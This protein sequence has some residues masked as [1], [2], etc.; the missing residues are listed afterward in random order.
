M[1]YKFPKTVVIWLCLGSSTTALAQT[2]ADTSPPSDSG[3][4]EEIVVT[5]QKRQ[6]SLNDVGLT[7]TAAT[8]DTL[9]KRGVTEVGDL[10]KIVPG[11]TTTSTQYS[12]PVYQLRG[13]GLYDY[14]FGSLPP[15]AVYIDEISRPFPLTQI[16]V[17]LDIERVEVLKGPQGTLYGQSSTGGA[18]N[19]ITAKPT[20]I[21]SAG[22]DASYERFGKMSLSGFVSGPLTDTLKARIALKGVNGGAWQYSVARPDDKNGETDQLMGRLIVDFEPTDTL[23]F[24]LNVNGIRDSSDTVQPQFQYNSINLTP[25]AGSSNPFAQVDPAAY[26]GLTSPSSPNFD[27]SFFHRQEVVLARRAG[28]PW[29]AGALLVPNDPANATAYLAGPN[30]DG[31]ALCDSN[32]D[33]CIRQA[34]WTPGWTHSKVSLYQVAFRADYDLSDNVTITSLTS[35]LKNK[36][37]R[38]TDEDATTAAGYQVNIF[39]DIKTFS[40]ELRLSGKSAGL[41]WVIGGNFDTSKVEQHAAGDFWDS[42]L[43]EVFPGLR[44][45]WQ[46]AILTQK[47]KNYAV[48]ANADYEVA[49]RLT[50]QGGLRYTKTK[51]SGSYCDTQ[52]VGGPNTSIL[53]TFGASNPI[54]G[55]G[56]LDLQTVF[57]L[58]PAG[59]VTLHPG[60]CYALND[61]APVGSLDYLRPTVIPFKV[62]LNEDN[63]SFRV[64]A[65]YKFDSGT[66]IYATLS[67]GYKAGIITNN[68]PSIVSQYFPAKQE[69]VIA[70]EAGIKAPLFDRRVQFN[71]AMFYYDYT[72]KQLRSRLNDPVFGLLE[73]VMNVPKSYVWGAEAELTARPLRGLDLSLSGA[74]LK[75]E[76]SGH[77]ADID[78]R[79]VYNQSG[80]KGDFK[81]SPLPYTAKFSGVFDAQY[82]APLAGYNAF[83]GT[84]VT[85]TSKDSTTF[86][87]DVLK[88]DG[89][90]RRAHALLDLRAGFADPDG[91]WRLTLFGRNITNKYY[92]TGHYG[93]TDTL[94]RYAGLPRIY[95]LQLS[96]RTR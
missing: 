45:T 69:K 39:G 29:A 47:M 90:G 57:G 68:S 44:L 91:A 9:L 71:T 27:S 41:N 52:P 60:E 20:D 76:V 80:Y 3:G 56:Y 73:V 17:T 5:A 24:S 86:H 49:P 18:I 28:L 35:Y 33:R 51:Q 55:V 48:F 64:G 53:E 46:D 75:S 36:T 88:A 25:A 79:T 22:L 82:E 31:T 26:A 70:Y 78:G 62:V 74:Y 11:F 59:H 85:Y 30:G 2:S 34:E 83:V 96:L 54:P 38:F 6:Q 77:F 92:E 87:N 84:T 8:Q 61:V 21:F 72:N 32:N 40:Q 66:L 43:N 12:T 67:Q 1:Q 23:R 37:N 7:I 58:D 81:G 89:Y 10:A 42:S 63:I 65:N 19:Y 16:G 15:V 93:V 14:G 95:G 50:I 94:Y 13:I 4:L